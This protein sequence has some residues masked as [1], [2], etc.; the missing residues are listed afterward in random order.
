MPYDMNMFD[1]DGY[2]GSRAPAAPATVAQPQMLPVVIGACFGWF[3]QPPP[4]T[5]RDTAI[6]LCAGLARDANTGYRSFHVLAQKLSAA[7]FPALRYDYPGT[8]DS[9]DTDAATQWSAWRASV[10]AAIDWMRQNQKA[11]RIV[12]IG[13]RFGATLAA[14]TAAERTDVCGLVLLEPVWRGKSYVSQLAV[15][16]RIRANSTTIQEDG[17]VASE[18]DLPNETLQLMSQVDLRRVQLPSECDTAIFRQHQSS[19]LAATVEVWRKGGARVSLRDFAGLEAFLRPAHLA[20]EP[21]IDTAPILSWLLTK[22][23]HR[24]NQSTVM[25]EQ[26]RPSTLR[27]AGCVETPLRFGAQRHL[28]GILCRPDTELP[29]DRVVIIGNA[30]GDPHHGFARFAV[31]LSRQLANAGVAALR[32]DFAGLGDSLD[33]SGN[34]DQP[35]HVFGISR[36]PD[37]R[38]AVDV[39][40]TLGYRDF[41]TAGLCSGAYHALE[42]TLADRRVGMQLLINLPLFT[43][44]ADTPGPSSVARQRMAGLARRQ[45]RTLLLFSDGD[46]GLK[47]LTRHFGRNGCDLVE[48]PHVEV[49]IL[50]G[51]DHD[52]T[53]RTMRKRVAMCLIDFLRRQHSP[54][55]L[56]DVQQNEAAPLTADAIVATPLTP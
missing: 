34:L 12:L 37:I 55:G 5:V 47:A 22:A 15:E 18:C 28:V 49:T 56:C 39:L 16:S 21:S 41:I 1:A 44:Q 36:S 31:E 25:P 32:M 35:T 27:P 9:C 48:D 38:A 33:P 13:L 10:H 51:L 6:V 30:G 23:G 29:C 43:L 54:G 24:S 20:D 45:V 3:H 17:A 2:A 7:G 8:G 4:G 50:S 40:G 11:R 42:G 14:L 26:R 52:L 53:A 46:A 19:L